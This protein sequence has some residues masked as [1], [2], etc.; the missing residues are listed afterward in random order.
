MLRPIDKKMEVSYS[1]RHAIIVAWI[2]VIF[3]SSA[4]TIADVTAVTSLSEP[5]SVELIEPSN[6]SSEPLF[7]VEGTLLDDLA[8]Q[9]SSFGNELFEQ[10]PPVL[11]A[12]TSAPVLIAVRPAIWSALPLLL[13]VPFVPR[14]RRVIG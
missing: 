3:A 11:P 8:A 12:S 4:V 1:S 14:L 2:C 13:L 7:V 9:T 6:G 5:E 10:T